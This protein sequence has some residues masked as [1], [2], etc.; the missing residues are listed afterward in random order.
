M[1]E[2]PAVKSETDRTAIWEALL[3]DRIDVIATD[4]A[5]HTFEEKNRP[6]LQAPSGGP[7]VQHSLI[8]MLEFYHQGKITLEKIA[9]KMSHDVA[10][11]FR[12]KERG[13]IREGFFADMVIVD[14][15]QKYIVQKDNLLYKCKWSPFE[16]TTFGSTVVTTLVNGN[17]V[18]DAGKIVEG[19]FGRRLSFNR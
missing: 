5:P 15:N 18:Y 8:A 10:T 3:D 7:L 2:N 4:H 11:C 12:I 13:Y 14:L 16:G 9:S 1:I 6:Y 17:I 19:N